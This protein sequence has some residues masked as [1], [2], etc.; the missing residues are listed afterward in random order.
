MA[1]CKK[2]RPKHVWIYD[3]HEVTILNGNVKE[4]STGDSTLSANY[5]YV[6]F[7]EQGNL[8]HSEKRTL[9]IA[10]I[11]HETDSTIGS[12]Q[13]KYALQHNANGNK[14]AIIGSIAGKDSL[15]GELTNK[16]KWKYNIRS[17]WEFDRR[18]HV[19]YYIR[20]IDEPPNDTG[21]YKL[22]QPAIWLNIDEITGVLMIGIYISINM[23]L[24]I[25]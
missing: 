8:T 16:S 25:G 15:F 11:E 12:E 21:R 17:K 10:Q 6:H 24:T 5:Y 9:D 1:S 19:I 7:D 22:V 20:G 4:V 14:I 13:I 3:E 23:I 2:E 18:G